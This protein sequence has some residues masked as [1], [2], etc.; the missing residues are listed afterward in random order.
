MRS[1]R[2]IT[3]CVVH[4]QRGLR[5]FKPH[6]EDVERAGHGRLDH[7]I[8]VELLRRLL[9]DKSEVHP[10]EAERGAGWT[11]PAES[12]GNSAELSHLAIHHLAI[13]L[14]WDTWQF[15]SWQFSGVQPAPRPAIL[16]SAG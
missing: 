11:P 1:R 7:G 16:G 13:R 15:P 12:R 4:C 3:I 14:S 2:L 10:L 8:V 6:S 9:K 5:G